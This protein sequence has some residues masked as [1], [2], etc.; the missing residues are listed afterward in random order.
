MANEGTMNFSQFEAFK[1]SPYALADVKTTCLKY[2]F[3]V[4]SLE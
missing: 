1:F 3:M 4:P 2:V